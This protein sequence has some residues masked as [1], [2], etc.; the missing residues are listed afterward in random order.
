MDALLARLG[1]QAMNMAIRSGLA[2]TSTYA[3][4]QCSRLMKTVDDR[5]IRAELKKLQKVLDS[6]IKV[7]ARRSLT[8]CRLS[9]ANNISR[10]SP[11]RLT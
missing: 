9:D 10:S 3:F 4:S 7:S 1:V 8:A 2:L 5:G 6:K 11:L